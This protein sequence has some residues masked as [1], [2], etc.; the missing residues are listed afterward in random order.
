[1]GVTPFFS[2]ETERSACAMGKQGPP[3][4]YAILINVKVQICFLLVPNIDF[5]IK[6]YGLSYLE[7]LV[8]PFNNLFEAIKSYM[9]PP[10]FSI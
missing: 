3:L 5:F 10:T 4:A 7:P 2:F 1:M 6:M 9:E 8:V